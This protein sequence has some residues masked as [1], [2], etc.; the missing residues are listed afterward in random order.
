MVVHGE[1]SHRRTHWVGVVRRGRPSTV[2]AASFALIFAFTA[3]GGSGTTVATTSSTT[4]AAATA[5]IVF[6]FSTR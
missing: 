4:T 3:L 5:G 6:F 1:G 2:L